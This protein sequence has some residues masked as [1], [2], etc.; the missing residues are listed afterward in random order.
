MLSLPPLIESETRCVCYR[1][2][3]MCDNLRGAN[4]QLEHCLLRMQ[5]NLDR[6]AQTGEVASMSPPDSEKISSGIVGDIEEEIAALHRKIERFVYLAERLE[7][8]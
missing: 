7:G 1:I 5:D 2:P 4:S 8:I 6:L 3:G